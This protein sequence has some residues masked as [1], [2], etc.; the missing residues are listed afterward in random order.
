[1]SN[2]AIWVP[3]TILYNFFLCYI[4]IRG[5]GKPFWFTYVWMS[6][7]SLLP[8]WSLAAY[9]SKNLIFDGLLYD[10]L[11]VVTSVIFMSM[12]GQA[13]SFKTV[14]WIGVLLVL[15]GLVLTRWK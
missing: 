2:Y 14:N 12:L 6:L 11:L 7:L 15:V 9:F 10:T 1:M 4:A 5:E 3:L 13:T 8:T